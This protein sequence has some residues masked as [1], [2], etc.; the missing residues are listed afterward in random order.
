[1]SGLT[2][3][4]MI[5]QKQ[6]GDFFC[7]HFTFEK[8][9]PTYFNC[10]GFGCNAAYFSVNYPFKNEHFT[11]CVCPLFRAKFK[12]HDHPPSSHHSH[13]FKNTSV[14]HPPSITLH[15]TFVSFSVHHTET[16]S[17]QLLALLVIS[18][19]WTHTKP[20]VWVYANWDTCKRVCLTCVGMKLITCGSTTQVQQT[21][22]A[23]PSNNNK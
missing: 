23:Q 20:Q 1:M 8:C 17:T 4:W 16:N 2:D 13:S 11:F 14:L 18:S 6:F 7:C 12:L 15:S 10:I 3:T 21:L 9:V 5:A 22:S 19:I